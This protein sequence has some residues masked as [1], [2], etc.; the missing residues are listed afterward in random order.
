MEKNKNRITKVKPN[1]ADMPV[2]GKR[3]S[4]LTKRKTVLC[5]VTKIK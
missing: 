4:L 5:L 2:S 1:I 3:I